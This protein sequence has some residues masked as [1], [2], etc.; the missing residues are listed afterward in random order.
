MKVYRSAYYAANRK[1]VKARVAAY[2]AAYRA[3]NP[4]KFAAYQ[5]AYRAKN[6]K[7]F[8]AYYA[9]NRDAIIL[10]RKH[11]QSRRAAAARLRA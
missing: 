4:K 7:K 6:R 1:K 10:S 2:H 9:A 8:A 5:A 11:S 3:K